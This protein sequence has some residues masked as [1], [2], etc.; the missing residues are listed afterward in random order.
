MFRLLGSLRVAHTEEVMESLNKSSS[1]THT[2]ASSSS[3][4]LLLVSLR[5]HPLCPGDTHRKY[6]QMFTSASFYLKKHLE[7]WQVK[8]SSKMQ[9]IHMSS[10]YHFIIL[11]VPA[12]DG[13]RNTVPSRGGKGVHVTTCVLSSFFFF[14]YKL[15]KLL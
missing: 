15:P 14:F 13:L 12:M 1:A 6:R 5:V 9:H 2:Y 4:P 3:S 7:M 11:Q 8:S 10:Y